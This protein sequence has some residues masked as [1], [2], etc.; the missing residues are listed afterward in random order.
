M[1]GFTDVWV[2]LAASPLTWLAVT[3]VAYATSLKI[4]AFFKGS[5]FANNVLISAAII[6][7]ILLITGTSYPTYFEGAQFVHFLLG[8]ATVA[9]SIPLFRNIG[10]VKRSLVPIAVSLVVGAV[11]A[12]A[13]AVGIVYFF[14]APAEVIASITPKSVSAPIAM[15][16]AKS[17]GGIPSLAAVL[18][19]STGITGA[20]LVTPLMNALKIK[21]YAARGFAV[22]VTSHGIGTARALQVSDVGGAFSGIGMALNGAFTALIV[23]GL[24]VLFST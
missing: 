5:P 2:Y 4:G 17:L 7:P 22:G 1:T 3:L 16:L 12:M 19:I 9:L 8:P 10:A 15:D 23:V 14:G 13:S 20:I 18:G 21:N 11:V 6:I 24:Q